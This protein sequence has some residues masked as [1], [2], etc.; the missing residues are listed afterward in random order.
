MEIK[1]QEREARKRKQ[2]KEK[3]GKKEET[4]YHKKN[5]ERK[6]GKKVITEWR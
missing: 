4:M 2:I 1:R 6:K 5:K 3:T